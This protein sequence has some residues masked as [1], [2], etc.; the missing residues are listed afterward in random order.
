MKCSTTLDERPVLP[1]VPGVS[2]ISGDWQELDQVLELDLE[3]T[4]RAS[5]A[6]LRRREI[7]RAVDL[8]R[9][10]LVYAICD[11]S[12]RMVGAW[13]VVQGLGD[14]SDVAVMQRLRHSQQW[15]GLLIGSMLQRRCQALRAQR[16]VRVRLVDAT[17][18]SQPGSQ[19][20]DWRMHLSLDLERV[21]LDGIAVTDARG[22]E[23]L[24]RFPAA[25]GEI[26]VADRG[27]AFASSLGPPLESGAAL[28]VRINWQN[29][30]LQTMEGQ[31]CDLVVWL[32]SLKCP[33]E[34]AVLL[35]TPQGR[36]TLRLCAYP[37]PQEAA[38]RARHRVRKAA[39]KKGRTP[40]AKSLFAAGFVLVITNLPASTWSLA[41]ICWL[42][43][44]R[45]QVEL[46]IKRFKSLL[47]M[48][49]LRARDP[50]L[51]QTYLLAKLLAALLLDGLIQQVQCQQPAWF[52]SLER[53]VSL[54]RLTA[55]LWEGLCQLI[56]GHLSLERLFQVLPKLQRYFCDRPRAR[57]Q[58]LAW[59]R[60][61]LR[62]LNSPFSSSSSYGPA[63]VP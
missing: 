37:L 15:L 4:A 58:Q 12:L 14:L 29:L 55:C 8:L 10:I 56:R 22:G 45:W 32:R 3:S 31:P 25:A 42:Y 62:Q 11:W 5:R 41:E 20:T 48:D 13:A 33:A 34:H 26:L 57:P 47:H 60:A 63:Y 23:T 7:R 24:V 43:R 50:R 51:V 18:I 35:V 19:G 40:A 38:D 54:W 59:A 16:P 61:F 39:V 52:R 28:V 6:L 44:L 1:D 46:H 27:Y 9:L 36:F 30:P 17:V 2:L 49:R 53:P 21:C